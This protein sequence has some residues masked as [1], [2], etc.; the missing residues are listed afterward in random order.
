MTTLA[1]LALTAAGL[2]VVGTLVARR[3]ALGVGLVCYPSRDR[4]STTPV[5]LLGGP[6]MMMATAI[7]LAFVPN[8][9]FQVGVLL[10]GAVGLGAVGLL[11]DI[12]PITPYSKLSAQVIVA[13]AVTA[14][15]LRFPL[16]GMPVVDLVIT[17]A[18]IIGLSN[19]FNLLDNMDGLAAGVAA[20]TGVVKMVLL[21]MEGEWAGAGACAVFVGAAVGFLTMNFAP[22]RI[23][24]GDAGSMF[25]GF[26]VAGLV[27]IGGTPDSRATASVVI[28]PVLVML[29][30]IFDTVF[31]TIRR[32]LA[33]RPIS[34]GG[35]DHTSH[36][37]VTAGLTERR[38]VLTLY[39]L[40][41]ASGVIAIVTRG[42]GLQ[43]GLV[44][45]AALG[46]GM[47]MLAVTLARIRIYAAD[48]GMPSGAVALYSG[49]G[50]H[51]VRQV[52][53]AGIDGLLAVVAFFAAHA[54]QAGWTTRP[55]SFLVQALP[56]VLCC[57]MIALAG[58]RANRR[59]WR[60]T[61]S[62][63]L[64]AMAV[65]SA[66]GS[67]LT[68]SA[69]FAVGWLEAELRAVVVLDW[70][71]LTGLLAGSRLSLRALSEVLRPA[72]RSGARVLIY[73][74]GDAGVTLLQELRRNQTL[75][76]LAVGFLDD[77][78]LKQRTDVQGVPVLGGIA[79]LSQ[80]LRTHSIEELIISTR[81]LP[82]QKVERIHEACQA[83]DVEVS[84]FQFAIEQISGTPSRRAAFR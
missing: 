20:I 50:A 45:V 13:G 23:C 7:T 37:L 2:A 5:P 4:W 82:A 78:T 66:V 72:S 57:K 18:W 1:V 65:A 84:Q 56:I 47:L 73:G 62:H 3:V 8:L 11:D 67:V 42:A 40:A 48:Q 68:I 36:H 53:T 63:D 75:G 34:Q 26:F 12:R 54:F 79:A 77:D 22:A 46:L 31:V 6:A 51:Y 9:P 16:T 43:L 10:A 61:D 80:V 58:F 24:M 81:K 17:M 14:M 38:A 39:A 70:V 71:F 21:V 69:L 83:A 19:A 27:T 15:G 59:M 49:P 44:L 41:G 32:V 25:L 29:V 52:M 55:D 30:P 64:I 28:A 76:R 33:G 60:Y 74:A 35:R